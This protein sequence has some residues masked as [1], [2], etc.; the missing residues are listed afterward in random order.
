MLGRFGKSC[1]CIARRSSFLVLVASLA[2]L[3]PRL[4]SAADKTKDVETIN[5]AA[6]VLQAMLSSDQVPKD[7]LPKA[8][9]IIVL[10]NVKKA[11]FGIG[12]T[13]GRGPMS[14]R[15]GKDFTG[16]WSAPAMYTVG[17]A[18]IGMQIGGS[19]SDFVLLLLTP[20]AVGAVLK[21]KTKLGHDATVAAGPS[22]ATSAGTV[23]GSDIL[24]YGRAKGLFA[25][26][27]LGG[28]DLSPDDDANN[29]LYGKAITA[30]DIVLE[31]AV[32]PPAGTQNFDTLLNTK[33]PKSSK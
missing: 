32:K 8:D 14:C 9:C 28:A 29:R 11:G 15:T 33:I 18:S 1:V 16:K 6:T 20:K 12:G 22:G 21:G 27:S 17:G 7:V 3:M 23:S 10:P 4:A 24:S 2:I 13:G 25:G 19:S 30:K 26:M 31:N 5:N